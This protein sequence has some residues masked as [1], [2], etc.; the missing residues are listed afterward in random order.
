MNQETSN[1][2]DITQIN[3]NHT[4][5]YSRGSK[6]GYCEDPQGNS[7]TGF[8]ADK[9]SPENYVDLLDRGFRR[10]GTYYYRPDLFKSCCPWFTIRVRALEHTP[11]KSHKKI[12]NR[13]KRF[14]AGKRDIQEEESKKVIK[15]ENMMIEI[16]QD[17]QKTFFNACKSSLSMFKEFLIDGVSIESIGFN[18]L[19]IDNMLKYDKKSTSVL[20]ST[21]IPAFIG[22]N[23]KN[24]TIKIDQFIKEKKEELISNYQIPGFTTIVLPN[25]LIRFECSSSISQEPKEIEK[26]EESPIERDSKL[27]PHKLEKK[28]VPAKATKENFALYK[29]YCKEIHEKEKESAS[30][31]E[32]FLCTRGLLES[33]LT[34]PLTGKTLRLGCYH[35]NYYL[36]GELIGVGV[37]DLLPN[38]LSSVYFF[39]D[40][41]YKP[42]KFGV[43]SALLELDWIREMNQSFPEFKYYYLGYYIPHCDKMNYKADYEPVEL[44]CPKNYVYVDY[45]AMLKEEVLGGR[46]QLADNSCLDET[47]EFSDDSKKFCQDIKYVCRLAVGDQIILFSML[48]DHMLEMIASHCIDTLK[49][50]GKKLSSKLIFCV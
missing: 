10:C 44:L 9:V 5:K 39:Y 41:K 14:M 19:N 16:S 38:G 24:L 37:I 13:W 23:S 27:R 8:S 11:R 20:V 29:K 2:E 25:G 17:I 4:H 32:N 28:L 33:K 15:A 47:N 36:D 42:L 1:R 7:T 18:G 48:Q 49:A 43:V 3:L 22:R 21:F 50:F 40:P 46:I 30:S 12:M 6:C 31:Y 26:G 34:S 45:T 35:M